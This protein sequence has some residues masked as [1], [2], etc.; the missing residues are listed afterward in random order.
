VL[1]IR[2]KKINNNDNKSKQNA[3]S[4]TNTKGAQ[5][6]KEDARI[7]FDAQ[8]REKMLQFWHA[9]Q[10]HDV[11]IRLYDGVIVR[12]LLT[13]T[14]SKQILLHMT[15][16]QTPMFHYPRALLRMTDVVSIKVIR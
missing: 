13:G 3:N 8:L 12:G 1:S 2:N 4:Y 15:N 9:V 14:D 7:R 16:L 10:G 11:E 6:E 5:E